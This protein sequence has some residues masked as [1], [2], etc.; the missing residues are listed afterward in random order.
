MQTERFCWGHLSGRFM[1]CPR[2][3][4]QPLNNH[5]ELRLSSENNLIFFK[6]K[7]VITIKCILSTDKLWHGV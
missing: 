6:K 7:S 4:I 5:Q 1:V 2:L 3:I